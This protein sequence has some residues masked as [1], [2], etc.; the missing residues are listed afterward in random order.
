MM[1][2]RHCGYEIIAAK[3]D[4]VD[5][6]LREGRLMPVLMF[7]VWIGLAIAQFAAFMDG[8]R[9]W[10]HLGALAFGLMFAVLLVLGP[11]GGLIVSIA[12]F[13]GAVAVWDWAW[14]QALLLVDPGLVLQ[15]VTMGAGGVVTLFASRRTSGSRP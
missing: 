10:F 12:A 1:P 7:L 15:V 6:G 3:L 9:D 2:A 4:G 11:F 8:M 13:H 5:T 14:W